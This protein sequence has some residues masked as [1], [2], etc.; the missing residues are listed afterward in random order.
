MTLHA[1]TSARSMRTLK[2]GFIYFVLV[3]GAGFVLGPVRL[4]WVVPRLGERLAELIEAP[5]MLVVIVMSARWITKRL[6]IDSTASSRLGMGFAA[7]GLIL[8]TEFSL[9]LW[10]RGLRLG[11]YFATRDPVSGTA[12]YLM[13]VTFALMPFLLSKR[14]R[15]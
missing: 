13:L 12:Y 4:L 6:A 14:E 10:L 8:I 15:D 5:I 2:A 1:V 7:L 9:V 3:F 11:E